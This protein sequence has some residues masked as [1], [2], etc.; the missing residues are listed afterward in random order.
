[1]SR[2]TDAF[3][4][5]TR[6]VNT[7]NF[8]E[9][10]LQE[11]E[12]TL[13]KRARCP[14]VRI[15]LENLNVTAL[16]DSGSQV[17]CLSEKFYQENLDIFKGCPCLPISQVCVV[18]A[19]GG[20]P[21]R[22]R[23]QIL[24]NIR[25][26]KLEHKTTM[27]I[28]PNLTKDCV[29]G[30][31][32]LRSVGGVI[33]LTNN[34]LTVQ[35]NNGK[36]YVTEMQE[37]T[38]L[39]STTTELYCLKL[40]KTLDQLTPD[41]LEEKI[42]S[43]GK[44]PPQDQ[45]KYKD[46]LWKYRRVFN[47]QPG[48]ISCY[49]HR[50]TLKE[51]N[52]PCARTYP[53]PLKYEKK[54]DEQIQTMIKWGI[55][56]RSC[57]PH[58]NPLVATVKK[59]GDIRLCL[60]ARGL[61]QNLW[62]DHEGTENMETLFQRCRNKRL[63][64]SLDMNMSFWQIPLHPSSKQYTAFLYKGRCYEHNVTPFGLKTSTSA[65]VR[66]LDHVLAGLHEFIIS[67][68]DDLLIAS[69]NEEDHLQ[70]LELILERFQ[71]HNVTLNFQKC[72]FR[73]LE[74]TFLG[75]II[76]AQGIRPDPDKI[77]AIKDFETPRNK[78][79]QQSF[80]GTLNFSAKFSSQISHELV[81]ILEL[82]KKGHKWAWE[83]RHQESFQRVKDL[84]SAHILL[85]FPDLNKPFY[86]QTDAS[87]FAIGAVLY[88]IEASGATKI[89]ACGSR[90]LRGSEVAYF[91]TEK[92][93]LALVWSLQKYRNFLWRASIIHRTDHM[94]LTFL[95]SCKLLNQR[96]TRWMMAIQDY[97][98][99]SEFCPGKEN[100]IADAFSRLTTKNAAFNDARENTIILYH[101]A[102]IPR[103]AWGK[104]LSNIQSDQMEDPKLRKILCNISDYPGY[105]IL[106]NGVHRNCQQ[107]PKLCLPKSLLE[108]L[109]IECHLVY[110]HIGARKCQLMI[111]EDFYYPGLR[112]ITKEKLKACDTCQRNKTPT[113]S[114]HSV[115]YPIILSEPLETVFVD[116]Y[117]PLPTAK[118]GYKYILGIL[119]GF[120]KYIKLYP[121]RRQTTQSTIKKLFEYYIP[122]C[123]K[124]RRIVTDHGTQFT[125]QVWK[126]KLKKE[127]IKHTLT[128]IRHP[129]ANMVERANRELSKFFKI[130]LE[131]LK[132]SSWYDKLQII[133]DIIN[134]THH[135]TTEFTPMELMMK[136][137]PRR[138]WEKWLPK[139]GSNQEPSYEQKLIW[140]H[141]RMKRKGL[142][143]AQ[144][145]NMRHRLSHYTVGDRVLIKA[146]NL[147][148]KLLKRTSKF[149]SVF[150]GPY[151]IGKII[152][153]G[154]YLIIDS[155]NNK[156]RGI[157]HAHDLRK[158]HDR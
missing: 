99:K 141:D 100:V 149:M 135:D 10:L 59:S 28:V 53:I 31:D 47:S 55:I 46:L 148:D 61:N 14:T 62:E 26:S 114:S 106:Q 49:Y 25:I 96:L 87:N 52:L 97:Q 43:M 95:R 39:N 79:Q 18:G 56:R 20:R 50:L 115:S 8:R 24:A 27:L 32:V 78:K 119:D 136:K 76:S 93:L 21:I 34:K 107:A 103:K 7:L 65:L 81:P 29:L 128:S 45:R 120:S 19:T 35:D 72:E 145:A 58:I 104:R 3:L 156:E 63:M 113:Q 69:E 4:S 88:Q 74:I 17:S 6:H 158:Y 11:E 90:T 101:L 64:S 153:E 82:L 110:G 109:I 68:V 30:I 157:F 44:I 1:M 73:Q 140:T 155:V 77:Q 13:E 75:H 23:K 54:A 130:L 126:E 37:E 154:T 70:H 118:Y 121:L 147:S 85:N 111:S 144:K 40:V 133:E 152:R 108:D 36:R 9:E 142:K 83:E 86:L 102:K 12:V 57:S 42:K 134:E 132:H 38:G 116:Y 123:G 94:A 48:R 60:D 122:L 51:G 137:K 41:Q 129:Q 71:S 117:G 124:P 80:L 131:D 125:T 16:A 143:R 127:G 5:I 151:I 105:L 2:N 84:L 92:E 98:I 112:K 67:Y 91:T 89:I 15:Q 138:F 150:E 33:D 146:Y 139:S 22:L 66:G